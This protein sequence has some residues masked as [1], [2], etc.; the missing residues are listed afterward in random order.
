MVSQLLFGNIL[1]LD[2]KMMTTG[3]LAR[4]I[5]WF[6]HI[7]QGEVNILQRMEEVLKQKWFFGLITVDVAEKVLQSMTEPNAFLVRLNAGGSTAIETSPFTISRKDKDNAIVHT[8]V[9]PSKTG[10]YYVKIDGVTTKCPGQIG[11]FILS[12]QKSHKEICGTIATG[13]P[14]EALFAHAPQKKSVYQ[15]GGDEEEED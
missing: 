4:I 6:G 12:L 1:A 11:D 9:Y 14:F 5:K 13:H 8:R 15:A 3:K 7:I 10:G 2:S